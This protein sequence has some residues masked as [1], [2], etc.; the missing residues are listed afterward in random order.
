MNS[1][2]FLYQPKKPT[3]LKMVVIQPK[4]YLERGRG[5]KSNMC[6]IHKNKTLTKL[7]LVSECLKMTERDSL[8]F[9]QVKLLACF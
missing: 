9:L 4:S 5:E 6:T 2:T 8:F 1:G 3:D 7:W